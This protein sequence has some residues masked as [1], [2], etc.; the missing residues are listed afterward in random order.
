LEFTPSLE[1]LSDDP[2]VRLEVVLAAEAGENTWDD[3]V[4]A[5][6]VRRVTEGR[7]DVVVGPVLSPGY[8]DSIYLRPLGTRAFGFV[9]FE[10]TKD[11]AATMHGHGERVSV[12]SVKRGFRLLFSVVSDVA[13]E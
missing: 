12:A 4:F 1:K 7:P 8:T 10:V 11:E 2:H 5:A 9:P 3:P 6:I 13:S